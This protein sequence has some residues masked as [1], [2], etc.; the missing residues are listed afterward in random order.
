M[1]ETPKRP[2][3]KPAP[4]K[5]SAAKGGKAAA[6]KS[7]A[8]AKTPARTSAQT[9]GKSKPA[10][11]A[12]AK[13]PGK[14]AAS[15]ARA[16][17]P[18]IARTGGDLRKVTAA[19]RAK[20]EKIALVPT[21]GALHEGHNALVEK[22]KSRAD[23]TVVSIFV[24][25]TQFAPNEDLERYPRGEESDLKQL[26]ALGVDLVWAPSVD[27]MYPGGFSTGV[28]PGSAAA[29]L[30]TDFRPHFFG[31]VATVVAK[32][33]NQVRPDLAVFGEK[34]YQQFIV[35]RQL[36]RDLD[37]NVEVVGVQ[38][39][40]EK[41]GLAL[42]SRNAYLSES[43]RAVAPNLNLVLNEVA[44]AAASGASIAH[45]KAAAQMR[46][47]TLGFAKVD[48]VEVRDAQTLEPFDV[49]AGRPGRVLGA[50]WLGRTRLI[51]NVAVAL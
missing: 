41:D 47:L 46:L 23:R 40:R 9:P 6:G 48:Y 39:V 33:F 19:W 13:S 7:S 17:K 21:M 51:D 35:V 18:E 36:A 43:E 22:A 11:K 3:G 1:A 28:R 12:V 20:G 34:D 27:E 2:E 38:T 44:H 31:G 49:D 26:S 14:P 15:K 42:S 10:A 45:L 25:P 37:M 16:A 29:G 30:E 32:L 50:A 24:N 5:K 4:R 8:T